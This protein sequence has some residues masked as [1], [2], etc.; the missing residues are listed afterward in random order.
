MTYKCPLGKHQ[1]TPMDVDAIK[2]EGW[3]NDGILVVNVDSLKLNWIERQFI[4]NIG[5][6]LY[7]KRK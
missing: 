1:Q 4:Q 2:A 6:K 3:R 7:G 5:D